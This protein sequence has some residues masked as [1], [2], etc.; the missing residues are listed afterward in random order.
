MRRFLILISAILLIGVAA[1]CGDDV[2]GDTA[3]GDGAAPIPAAAGG[4]ATTTTQPVEAGDEPAPEEAEEPLE[5]I[6]FNM[7]NA[8]PTPAMLPFFIADE[9]GFY[10]EEGLEVEFVNLG[11]GAA[12]MSALAA[13][14]VDAINSSLGAMAAAKEGGF[15]L[16]IVNTHSRGFNFTL[17]VREGVEVPTEGSFE[18][19]MAALEGMTIGTQGGE[20]SLVFGFVRA[21]MGLAGASVETVDIANLTFGGP[22]IAA[23]QTGQVDVVVADE[24]TESIAKQLG[25]GF[26]FF[27]LL[28]DPPAEYQGLVISGTATTEEFLAAHPDFATRHANAMERAYDFI[29]T[30]GNLGDAERVA[31]DRVGLAPSDDLQDIIARSGEIWYARAPESLLQASID[32]LYLTGQL[33]Q[34]PRMSVRDLFTDS[35]I[36]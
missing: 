19:K 20:Q 11:S 30:P 25:L 1:S 34:E 12:F 14:E 7:A 28:D 26:R 15:D 24:V 23:L 35:A 10:Q 8:A 13:G 4:D 9:L 29:R 2:T 16:R 3:D 22:M 27:S 32:F 36:E 6:R 17:V 31:V 18:E 21:L 33:T 5:V